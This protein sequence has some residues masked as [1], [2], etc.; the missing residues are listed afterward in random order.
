MANEPT[1]IIIG[2]VR[3]S[4]LNVFKPRFN[5]MNE[6]TEYS[7]TNLLPKSDKVS[8]DK[9]KEALKA[10]LVAKFKA[11][12]DKWDNPIRDGDKETDN[13]G[14]AK[15]PGFW[16]FN[17]KSGEEYKPVTVNASKQAVGP[18]AG[19]KSGDWGNVQINCYGYE[20]KGKKGVGLGLLG[21][22]FTKVD[23][24]FGNTTDPA[25]VAAAF[26]GTGGDTPASTEDPTYDPFN[27]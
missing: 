5:E 10:A 22:Q 4:Y 6:K 16:F 3:F 14:E 19:W 2:P 17:T 7:V 26:S 20:F 18:E 23:A 1:K 13:N 25:A 12:P 9:I 8:I 24:G 11:V 21:I 27:E 15:Y